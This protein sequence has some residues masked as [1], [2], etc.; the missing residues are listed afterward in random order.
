MGKDCSPGLVPELCSFGT[1]DQVWPTFETSRVR[2]QP[3]GVPGA[4][5]AEFKGHSDAVFSVAVS[6]NG[7]TMVS[8]SGDRTLKVWNVGSGDCKQTFEGH[9]Q[10]V[11]CCAIHKDVVVSASADKTLKLWDVNSGASQR[12]IAN[13]DFALS[14]TLLDV[15]E[16]TATFKG[17]R[18]AIRACVFNKDG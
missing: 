3:A 1:F 9:T 17:H 13:S 14:A 11:R 2:S 5:S 7:R 16:C 18:D 10:A 8:A 12:Y 6:G 4:V 15:G